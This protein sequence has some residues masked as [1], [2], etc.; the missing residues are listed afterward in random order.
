MALHCLDNTTE[1]QKQ[2]FKYKL[3]GINYFTPLLKQLTE[4]I[5]FE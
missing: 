1:L 3:T 2:T 4:L 5:V